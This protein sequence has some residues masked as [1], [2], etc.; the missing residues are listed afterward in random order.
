MPDRL[1]EMQKSL[2]AIEGTLAGSGGGGGDASA[3]NQATQIAQG[4]TII[5]SLVDAFGTGTGANLKNILDRMLPTSVV[6]STALEA[7]RV[8]SVSAATLLGF[9]VTTTTAQYI[10]LYNSATVPADTTAP[11]ETIWVNVGTTT[12]DASGLAGDPYSTGIC[13]A[14]SST[15]ATKTLTSGSTCWFTVRFR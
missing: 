7:S 11:V 3:A 9:T 2:K 8:V 4:I 10:Q 12:F 1:Q 13:I 5:E 14:G 15:L 6:R